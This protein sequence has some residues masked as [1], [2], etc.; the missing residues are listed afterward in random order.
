MPKRARRRAARPE[1][2]VSL[3]PLTCQNISP[4]QERFTQRGYRCTVSANR[5]LNN[6]VAEIGLPIEEIYSAHAILTRSHH[7]L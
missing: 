7:K 4:G 1:P 5:L 6:N 2:L 3:A